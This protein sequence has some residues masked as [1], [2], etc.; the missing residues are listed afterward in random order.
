MLKLSGRGSI[1]KILKEFGI[2]LSMMH[3]VYLLSIYYLFIFII[4]LFNFSTFFNIS[5]F[6]H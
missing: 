5:K 4:I 1:G 2:K 3:F 6:L